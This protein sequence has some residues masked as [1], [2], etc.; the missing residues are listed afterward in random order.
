MASDGAHGST[1]V[2]ILCYCLAS[3]SMLLVNSFAMTSIKQPYFVLAFQMAVTVILMHFTTRIMKIQVLPLRRH[4]VVKWAPII[5]FFLVMLY[6]SA[7]ALVYVSPVSVIVWRNINLFSVAL[8]EF[9][10][11]GKRQSLMKSLSLVVV[12]TGAVLF[13]YE[14]AF[15]NGSFSEVAGVA[16]AYLAV[17]TLATTAYNLYNKSPYRPELPP[18]SSVFYNNVLSFVP[19]ASFSALWE[20]TALIS[21]FSSPSYDA[22]LH[23]SL[24][25]VVGFAISLCGFELQSRVSATSFTL[26]TNVNKIISLALSLLF[27]KG[28]SL[29]Q[30]AWI[31]LLLSVVGA[32]IYSKLA[33]SKRKQEKKE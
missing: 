16:Y 14:D 26:A 31:G 11:Y 17:N 6:T 15:E 21:V 1:P 24:S 4:M 3:S 2:W 10:F 25:G 12:A 22:L 18:L 28:K 29:T 9:I 27:L 32:L 30:S 19:V 33:S 13:A 23:L 7:M 20:R 8:G 5:V